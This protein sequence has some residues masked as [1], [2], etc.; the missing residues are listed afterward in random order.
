MP[1]CHNDLCCSAID[2]H[3]LVLWCYFHFR[4]ISVVLLPSLRAVKSL[5]M[6]KKTFLDPE[7]GRKSPCFITF[8]L[9][10]ISLELDYIE[11]RLASSR[12]GLI[13]TGF[14]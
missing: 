7:P 11:N 10:L 13:L 14:H 8:W 5:A 4:S 2:F 12:F 6:G 9:I 3:D 1:K